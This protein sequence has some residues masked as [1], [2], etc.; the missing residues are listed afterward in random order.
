MA[1]IGPCLGP[2]RG[3]VGPEVVEA[4]REAGNEPRAIARWF[5][6]GPS[7]RP[8]INLW[9]ANRDQ[10]EAAGIPA[11]QIFVAELCTRSSPDVFH[12]YRFAGPEAGRMAALARASLGRT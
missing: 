11:G 9:T 1:A 8:H 3:E 10:L 12:S 2:A 6:D 5:S 4:F 7:G